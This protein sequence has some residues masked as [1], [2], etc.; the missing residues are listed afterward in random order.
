MMAIHLDTQMSE[1]GAM[2]NTVTISVREAS[3]RAVFAGHPAQ[4]GAA[5]NRRPADPAQVPAHETAPARPLRPADLVR[6][7]VDFYRD[8]LARRALVVS[9]LILTYGGGAVLFW[10]HAI[11]LGEGGPAISPWLHWLL[12]SSAGFVGLTPAL[13]IILP[14]AVS[15]ARPAFDLPTQSPRLWTARYVILVGTLFALV[16]APG[17]ILHD[18]LLA[19]GTWVANQVTA[20][21][22]NGRVPSGTPHHIAPATDM[23]LQVA[24]AL[25]TYLLLTAIALFAVRATARFTSAAD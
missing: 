2:P 15:L 12:D 24:V 11:Y 1:G 22:G 21:L 20:M 9:A 8:P 23:S 19:R 17:P 5:A 25:P 7:V 6:L 16:T 14:I 3:P 13:A 10:F 4:R 18:K